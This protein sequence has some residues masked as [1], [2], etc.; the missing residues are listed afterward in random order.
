MVSSIAFDVVVDPSNQDF[1]I[2]ELAHD[3]FWLILMSKQDDFGIVLERYLVGY[4]DLRLGKGTLM[5]CQMSP[6]IMCS[7]FSM[8]R[9]GVMFMT[10]HP[11]DLADSIDRFRFSILW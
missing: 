9:V 2:S 7:R 6:R 11:I 8:I 4:V 1:L 3:V 10:V 5:I